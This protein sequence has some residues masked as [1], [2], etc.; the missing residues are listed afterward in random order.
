MAKGKILLKCAK[1][2]K[3]VPNSIASKSESWKKYTNFVGEL[4]IKQYT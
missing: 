1:C 4:M 2:D 3:E